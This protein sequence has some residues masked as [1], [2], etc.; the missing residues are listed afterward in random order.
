MR[1]TLTSI[2]AFALLALAACTHGHRPSDALRAN[3]PAPS[4]DADFYS[5]QQ[6]TAARIALGQ[7][8]FFDKILSGN[9]NISC[10]TC[11]NVLA[12]TGDGLSLSIG[13][14]GTGSGV[15][16]QAEPGTNHYGARVPRNA[17]AVFNLGAREFTTLFA[18]GRVQLDDKYPSGIDSPA[19]LKLPEGLDNPLAAQALFP[20]TSPTEMCGQPGENNVAKFCKAEDFSRIWETLAQRLR[21]NAEYVKLFKAAYPEIKKKSQINMVHAAN[22]IAIFETATWRADNSPFDRYLRGDDKAMSYSALAGMELFYGKADCASCHSGTF[23]TD[24]K[25]HAVAMPQLGPG[26]G[27]GYKKQD[28]FGR[29]RVT[30]DREDRYKFRTPSL[31]NVALTG[32]YGHAGAYNDLRAAV[33]H[34]IDPVAALRNYDASQAVLPSTKAY[35]AGDTTIMDHPESVAGIAA[36]NERQ[37]VRLSEQEIDQIIDFLHALTDPD[38]LDLRED[39]PKSVPSGL[40]LID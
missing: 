17:P 24:Q 19:K 28:D 26:K 5:N 23:Q 37:P 16:R 7:A 6:P 22:A 14:E 9:K 39:A 38:S 40:T 21:N 35:M 27:D 11:H 33:K 32:P 18:D 3:L 2:I 31:R 13:E 25:F 20:P 8:L 4:T 1:R 12:A 29:E 34:F 30:G 36:A 15:F 10:A